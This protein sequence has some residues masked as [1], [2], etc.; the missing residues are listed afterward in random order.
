MGPKR[1][2]GTTPSIIDAFNA[3]KK[4]KLNVSAFSLNEVI[5]IS[6]SQD[7]DQPGPSTI[8]SSIPGGRSTVEPTR[9]WTPTAKKPIGRMSSSA[10]RSMV[11][12]MSDS[13]L[14]ELGCDVEEL[15][16]IEA[17]TYVE[18]I[19]EDIDVVRRLISS[20]CGLVLVPRSV[21]TISMFIRNWLRIFPVG[22]I[23]ICSSNKE[24][25]DAV[26][27]ESDM[28]GIDKTSFTHLNEGKIAPTSR[29]LFC[30]SKVLQKLMWDSLACQIRCVIFHLSGNEIP[31]SVKSAVNEMLMN[32]IPTRFILIGGGGSTGGSTGA[33]SRRQR[34]ITNLHLSE[35]LEPK[36][37][38]F[39]MVIKPRL[40]YPIK[41]CTWTE[42]DN[43]FLVEAIDQLEESINQLTD[44]MGVNVGEGKTRDLIY[45]PLHLLSNTSRGM[46]DWI[47]LMSLFSHLFSFGKEAFEKRL[48]DVASESPDLEIRLVSCN[49]FSRSLKTINDL[50]GEHRKMR[51][52]KDIIHK[53]VTSRKGGIMKGL[54]LVD[55][56]SLVD[57][58]ADSLSMICQVIGVNVYPLGSSQFPLSRATMILHSGGIAIL[59]I[60]NDHAL[61]TFNSIA[62]SH[63]NVVIST[64]RR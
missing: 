48:A 29:L 56:Q 24:W 41:V 59:S 40:Q 63:V 8:V 14:R 27:E 12:S 44:G 4:P 22:R 52:I 51:I 47:R 62:S 6:D 11:Q 39:N 50:E 31:P 28:M 33:I 64:S 2:G 7:E 42:N 37:V 60:D 32:N 38:L 13:D 26:I 5:D 45:A 15:K 10:R 21:F 17:S 20:N 18:C 55:S 16:V 9:I 19:K 1:K 34:M 25:M 36:E 54:L 23:C 58:V 46:E 49:L 61:N 3:V 35:W 43:P 30:T 57:I 53:T